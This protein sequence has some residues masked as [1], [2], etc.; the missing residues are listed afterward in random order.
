MALIA[1]LAL[2][3]VPG[4]VGSWVPKPRSQVDPN[5]F[6]PSGGRGACPRDGDDGSAP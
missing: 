3:A 6:K 2:V 4:P 1:V 5:L